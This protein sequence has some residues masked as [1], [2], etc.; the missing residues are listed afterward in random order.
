[1]YINVIINEVRVFEL[2]GGR[3]QIVDNKK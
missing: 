2:D 3:V 1:M